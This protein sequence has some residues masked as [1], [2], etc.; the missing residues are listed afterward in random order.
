MHA[1]RLPSD[2]ARLTADHTAALAE[3][4]DTAR[5]L[6]PERWAVPL[7]PGKWSPAEVTGHLA[8]AYQ[9][10]NVE[11]AGGAGMR[12]LGSPLQR[13]ILRHTL[14]P[15]ILSSGRFPAHARAPAETRP[16]RAE[17][18]PEAGIAALTRVAEQFMD[19]LGARASV[20]RVRLTHAY[21][22]PLGLRQ[23]VRLCAVHTR[24]HARQLEAARAA[25]EPSRPSPAATRDPGNRS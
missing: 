2:R 4:A 13:W 9:V 19:A 22:G 21:F 1:S 10:L 3:F 5:G 12:L 8:E 17:A 18:R 23:A 20:E 7:T 16:L 25:T 14:L 15:R 24:H 11:L 6:P